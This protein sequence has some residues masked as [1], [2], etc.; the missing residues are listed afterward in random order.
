MFHAEH[1]AV[2]RGSAI[3]LGGAPVRPRLDT[4][5]QWAY[6]GA[7]SHDLW[8]P[9][10]S[11]QTTFDLL[12]PSRLPTS[13][14][15]S[16]CCC[17]RAPAHARRQL[18]AWITTRRSD[19]SHTNGSG[20]LPGGDA[21]QRPAPARDS[22]AAGAVISESESVTSFDE[23]SDARL[24]EL[25]QAD[26]TADT[27]PFDALV[28]RHQQFVVGNCRFLTRSSNDAEDLA[29]EV[30][31][32]AFFALQKFEGRSQFRGWLHR[33]KVNHCLNHLRKTRGTVMVDVEDDTVA[34]DPRLSAP[35]VAETEL[36]GAE[37]R[38]RIAHVL[39]SMADTLRIPLILRDADGLAYEEIAEQLGLRLSAVKMRIKRGREEFRRLMTSAPDAPA[40]RRPVPVGRSISPTA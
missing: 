40:G 20:I 22:R 19:E 14:P 36:E 18:R 9:T 35:A 32:K 12:S 11:P 28:R 38:E 39:D 2:K 17:D 23:E 21:P 29:Q 27:R 34:D 13:M 24:I 30:F 1:L 8:Y 5:P 6:T 16:P 10:A 4:N 25:L 37:R 31:V 26:R 33:I 7:S 15:S 3:G